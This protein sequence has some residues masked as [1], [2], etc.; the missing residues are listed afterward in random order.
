MLP[1][2]DCV[3]CGACANACPKNCLNMI[4]D[5]SSFLY[6]EIQKDNCINCGAC[7]KACPIINKSSKCILIITK[8]S[9]FDN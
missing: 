4:A 2:I 6:P 3:G 1:D 9:I 7:E 8:K 5:K